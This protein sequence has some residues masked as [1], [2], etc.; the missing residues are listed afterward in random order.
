MVICHLC[1]T[2]PESVKR[3]PNKTEDTVPVLMLNVLKYICMQQT[4]FV[5]Y[6]EKNGLKVTIPTKPFT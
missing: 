2:T 1:A 4:R 6:E 3:R 5:S